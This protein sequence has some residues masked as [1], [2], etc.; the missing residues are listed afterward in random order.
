MNV[1]S[2]DPLSKVL[3]YRYM[4][5]VALDLFQDEN[6]MY[7]GPANLSSSSATGD[8]HEP[9]N[10]WPEH[11]STCSKMVLL[12]A[13]CSVFPAAFRYSLWRQTEASIFDDESVVLPL[14]SNRSS[15]LK[16]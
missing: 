11:E 15:N 4:L 8:F 6:Q 9:G 12:R 5:E 16:L 10:I 7:C 1:F 14:V 13:Q 3:G 2:T